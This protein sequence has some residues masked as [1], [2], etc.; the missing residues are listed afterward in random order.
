MESV[1]SAGPG[2]KRRAMEAPEIRCGAG[3]TPR[4]RSHAAAR[5]RCV[6][7]AARFEVVFGTRG[8]S[9]RTDGRSAWTESDAP[10]RI[11]S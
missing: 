1:A 2:A 11:G 5:V 7:F 6:D 9:A 10:P 8:A 4:R 3:G